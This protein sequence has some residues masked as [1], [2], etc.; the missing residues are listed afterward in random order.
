M[1]EPFILTVKRCIIILFCRKSGQPLLIHIDP[2]RVNP[3]YPHIN[4][5]VKLQPIDQERVINVMADNNGG[6]FLQFA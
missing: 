5:Q 6:V 1:L 3:R 4:P 2:Q